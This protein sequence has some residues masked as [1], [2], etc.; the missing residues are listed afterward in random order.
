MVSRELVLFQDDLVF[1]Y[2]DDVRLMEQTFNENET[3]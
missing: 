3:K 1:Y 2:L